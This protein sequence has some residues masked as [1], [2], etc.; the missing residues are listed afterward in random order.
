MIILLDEINIRKG[1]FC[2]IFFVSNKKRLS[3]NIM[4]QPLFSLLI[5]GII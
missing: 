1:R 5:N 2:S 3:D 4:K